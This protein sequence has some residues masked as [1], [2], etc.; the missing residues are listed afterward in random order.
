[1]M[2]TLCLYYSRTNTTKDIM[3]A[4]ANHIGADIAEYTD[5]KDRSGF[6]GYIGACF[7]SVNNTINNVYIKGEIDLDE[8][9][10]VIIGMPVWVECPCV[11]GKALIKKYCDKMPSKVYFL[12]THM[13]KNDY[14]TKIKAMDNLLL[15]PSSGQ[16]SIK[17]KDNDYIKESIEYA[18]TID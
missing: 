7:A 15:K 16:F 8:Y 3:E 11:I 17:T 13:G 14:M 10:R 4:I 9:D 1:M 2:K 12:V 5:G 6:F 18:N